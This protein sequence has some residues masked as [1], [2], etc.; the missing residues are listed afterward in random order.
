MQPI[1]VLDFPTF[2]GRPHTRTRTITVLDRCNDIPARGQLPADRRL[3]TFNHATLPQVR[4]ASLTF[5][6][7]EQP[8]P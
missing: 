2:V 1:Q 5:I 6:N 8:A 7:R 3:S 4:R